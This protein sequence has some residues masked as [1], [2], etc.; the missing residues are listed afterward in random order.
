MLN[1]KI[2]IDESVHL[3]IGILAYFNLELKNCNCKYENSF[4]E[5][6]SFQILNWNFA[7]PMFRYKKTHE[8]SFLEKLAIPV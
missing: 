3:K 2:S 5:L 8:I 1:V 7:I 6:N 4:F